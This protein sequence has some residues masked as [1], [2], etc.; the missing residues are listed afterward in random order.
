MLEL[1]YF[2]LQVLPTAVPCP[3]GLHRLP[4]LQ[5]HFPN[6]MYYCQ[7]WGQVRIR[8]QMLSLPCITSQP[9]D[10][11][12]LRRLTGIYWLFTFNTTLILKYIHI[13]IINHTLLLIIPTR[14]P[15]FYK[16]NLS[17]STDHSEGARA[18]WHNLEFYPS[19]CICHFHHTVENRWKRK[20]LEMSM[21][22]KTN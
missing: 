21:V 7:I 15:L 2:S 16:H 20:G 17:I 19:L 22:R 5:K 3:P 12:P 8:L 18:E 14:L 10:C 1:F 9:G 13:F 4:L 6:C 11:W